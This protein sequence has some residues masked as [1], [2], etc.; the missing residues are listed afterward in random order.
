MWVEAPQSQSWGEQASGGCTWVHWPESQDRGQWWL[1]QGVG[2]ISCEKVDLG[3]LLPNV[4]I[5]DKNQIIRREGRRRQGWG[6]QRENQSAAWFA[7]QGLS[8]SWGLVGTPELTSFLVGDTGDR[9]G[10]MGLPGH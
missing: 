1:N 4:I 9:K 7:E 6:G 5:L 2:A 8:C 10:L 3:L